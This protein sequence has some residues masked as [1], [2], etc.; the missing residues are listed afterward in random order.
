MLTKKAVHPLQHVTEACQLQ[1]KLSFRLWGPAVHVP[2]CLE[3]SYGS[4]AVY[5]HLGHQVLPSLEKESDKSG[6]VSH[7]Q[8]NWQ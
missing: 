8:R 3:E 6:S 1:L 7:L 4:T 5:A 2:L